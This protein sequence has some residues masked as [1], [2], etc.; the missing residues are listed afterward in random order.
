M[1]KAWDLIQDWVDR[2]AISDITDAQLGRLIG[3]S[4]S[5]FPV[6]RNPKSLPPRETIGAIAK[7]ISVDFDTVR[8]AFLEDCGYFAPP[9]E[10]EMER[11]KQ[12]RKGRSRGRQLRKDQDAAGSGSQDDGTME[13]S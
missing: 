6:W 13:P 2:Q 11:A 12:A 10:V 3:F 9:T 4:Q 1:G 7:A 8:D 5:N